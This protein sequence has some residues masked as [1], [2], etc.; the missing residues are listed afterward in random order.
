MLRGED[1][2][3]L[4]HLLNSL[5]Q[6]MNIKIALMDEN[7]REIYTASYQTDFCR[8]IAT[9]QGG[10][11]RCVQCDHQALA[12]IQHTQKM[13]RYICHAGLIEIAL[14]VTENGKTIATILFGQLLDDTPRESQ[15]ER[16]AAACAWYPDM[17]ELHQAFMRLKRFS[18]RQIAACT[19]IIHACVS[20]VRLAGIIAP[21]SQDDMHRFSSYLDTHY[22]EQITLN[23]ICKEFSIGKTKLYNLCKLRFGKTV[24]QLLNERRIDAAKELL[25]TTTHPIQYIAEVVGILDFNYFTKV[26]K[27]ME[28]ITPSQ[29]RK[30]NTS[31]SEPSEDDDYLLP[32]R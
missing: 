23:D 17:E 30:I 28:G 11:S 24:N 20:E 13:K 5:H 6:C 12:D 25:L 19:E 14:P 26:F 29:Y 1:F 7:A 27:R 31:Q 21:P 9:T 10:Y 2:H 8:C 22:A 15:W 32:L 3:K 18:N 4:G 16:V